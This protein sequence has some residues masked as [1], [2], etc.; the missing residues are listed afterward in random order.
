MLIYIS[1]YQKKENQM[2]PYLK[3]NAT[4]VICHL[5]NILTTSLSLVVTFTEIF[6]NL[7]Y[8]YNIIVLEKERSEA[9]S[10]MIEV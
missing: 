10:S 2:S 9:I 5:I 3:S 4:Q 7:K 6:K 8:K 1:F